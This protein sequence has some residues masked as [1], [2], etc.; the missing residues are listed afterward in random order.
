MQLR[1]EVWKK[2]KEITHIF[3]GGQATGNFDGQYLSMGVLQW[4]LGQ[5]TLQPI[6][7]EVFE[8]YGAKNWGLQDLYQAIL[9]DSKDFYAQ[10][11]NYGT[12]LIEPWQT[13]LNEL[14]NSEE[15]QDISDKYCTH[16]KNKAIEICESFGITTDRAFC[17]AFDIAVQCGSLERYEM[18]ET[19][20]FDRLT[21]MAEVTAL[22]CGKWADDVRKRKMA[23]VRGCDQGR[24][25][26]GVEF[27]D[28][29]MY[30]E[31]NIKKK[32]D[33]D[34]MTREQI[35]AELLIPDASWGVEQVNKAVD[36]G[37]LTQ[38]HDAN[39]IVTMGVMCAMFNNLF[40][41]IAEL[42]GKKGE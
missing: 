14:N 29:S 37:I 34:I 38:K 36:N 3:E 10:I 39:E 20:Y 4:N 17:L 16:Y 30:E 19:E 41:Q 13:R 5:G 23:I 1:Q 27:D 42:M 31:E 21:S 40:G 22:K 26:A 9:D 18:V 33:E 25:W 6:L 15:F 28:K 7:K 24:G 32:E 8:T 35:R 2:A 12:R 11:N